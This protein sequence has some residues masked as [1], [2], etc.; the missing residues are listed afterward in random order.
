M[1]TLA[2]TEYE[3]NRVGENWRRQS[4]E[5][6]TN[7]FATFKIIDVGIT[8]NRRMD[9]PTIRPT[10]LSVVPPAGWLLAAG[11][12]GPTVHWRCLGAGSTRAYVVKP[13][14]LMN[15]GPSPVQTHTYGQRFI[16]LLLLFFITLSLRIVCLSVS[17]FLFWPELGYD[18][19]I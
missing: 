8:F 14:D 3:G 7:P 18:I 10:V 12:S 9:R 17:F 11:W 15:H 16:Y 19:M 5:E 1:Y 2:G 4:G 6:V 13:S